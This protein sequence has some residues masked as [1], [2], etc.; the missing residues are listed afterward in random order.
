V[1]DPRIWP[2]ILLLSGILAVIRAVSGSIWPTLFLHVAFN[3]TAVGMPFLPRLVQNPSVGLVIG[4]VVVS[5]ALFGV[6]A[7]I[8]R[9]SDSAD[10]ARQVDLEPDPGLGEP[11]S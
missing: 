10:R 11:Q 6:I 2:P 7:W 4:C 9:G 5:L 3:A 8:A 1:H